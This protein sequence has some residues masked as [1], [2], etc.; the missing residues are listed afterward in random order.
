MAER[1]WRVLVVEDD[2]AMAIALRDGFAF[3]GHA[4]EIAADGETALRRATELDPDLIILDVMLPKR[5]GLEVCAE[6]RRRSDVAIIM[7]TARG[8][9]EDKIQGLKGGADDYVTKPFSFLE[10]AARAEAV[11]RRRLRAAPPERAAFGDV[12]VDFRQRR[13]WRAGAPLDLS[14]R[15]IA[16]LEFLVARR[17]EIVTRDQLLQAVWGYQSFPFTRTVD[18]HIAKLRRKIEADPAEPR[19]IVTVH[20]SGYRFAG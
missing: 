14:E 8:Q 13:A 11:M 17:G 19:L 9:Q 20:G 10:L 7:L 12:E 5:S 16:L 1:C 3:D 4:V 15:E 18:M 6:L 2:P